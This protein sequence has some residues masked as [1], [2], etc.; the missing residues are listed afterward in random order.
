MTLMKKMDACE[1][2]MTSQSGWIKVNYEYDRSARC[3]TILDNLYCS[4]LERDVAV[5]ISGIDVFKK[6]DRMCLMDFF[7]GQIMF[8]TYFI[9]MSVLHC[10]AI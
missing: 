9:A 1:S 10:E 7:I 5:D 8:E 3:Q 2:I 6:K 4:I